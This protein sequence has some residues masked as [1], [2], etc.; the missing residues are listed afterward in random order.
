MY[1]A[2][3][4]CY[5][6]LNFTIDGVSFVEMSDGSLSAKVDGMR[7]CN[8]YYR[9]GKYRVKCRSK[10]FADFFPVE[11][12]VGGAYLE[13]TRNYSAYFA[14]L[15]EKQLQDWLGKIIT[16]DISKRLDNR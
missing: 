7:L 13:E 15:T 14:V 3:G 16:L 9:D 11:Y 6:K 12:T 5:M 8:I 4:G 10:Y 1:V 2:K